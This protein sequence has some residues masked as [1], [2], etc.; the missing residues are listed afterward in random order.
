M[1]SPTRAITPRLEQAIVDVTCWIDVAVEML[2]QAY[3]SLARQAAVAPKGSSTAGYGKELRAELLAALDEAAFEQRRQTA[4]L[5]A[6]MNR[7]VAGLGEEFARCPALTETA[8]GEHR[9]QLLENHGGLHLVV[10]GHGSEIRWEQ[11]VKGTN[12]R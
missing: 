5:F 2:D 1:S 12:D 7:G 4:V 6:A 11:S 8:W 9:C 10:L 3:N